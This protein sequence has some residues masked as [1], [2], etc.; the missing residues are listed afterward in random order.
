MRL[1]IFAASALFLAGCT[2]APVPMVMGPPVQTHESPYQDA[3]ACIAG[4]PEVKGLRIAVGNIADNTGKV[5]LAEGGTGSF[6]TK[7]ATDKFNSRLARVGVRLIVLGDNYRELVDWIGQRGVEQTIASPQ[8]LLTGS[9]TS[10]DFMPGKVMEIGAFGAS[11]R[12]RT[13]NANGDMDVQIVTFPDGKVPGGYVF[14]SSSL[15]KQFAAVE[16]DAGYASFI[17]SAPG[18]TFGSF[19]IG[20]GKR[21][22]M[23]HAIGFM[24]DFAVVELIA[25]L[26]ERLSVDGQIIDRRGETARCRS[27]LAPELYLKNTQGA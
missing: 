11:L 12:G 8:F 6:I 22:P 14:S 27:L 1:V 5:N 23:Q 7:G 25:G 20:A 21:E 10:L 26:V 9:I 13:Y 24:V 17:G 4:I 15:S 3:M 19:R 2:T 16:V 18:I